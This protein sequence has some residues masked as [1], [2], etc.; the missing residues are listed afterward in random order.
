M[1]QKLKNIYTTLNQIEI[2]GDTNIEYMYGVLF[3]LRELITELETPGTQS[4][5][6]ENNKKQ[7]VVKWAFYS[8]F[9]ANKPLFY[10]L[11]SLQF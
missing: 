7:P 8:S 2:K 10:G 5:E 4:Q 3:T 6:K 9:D 1:N 11:S